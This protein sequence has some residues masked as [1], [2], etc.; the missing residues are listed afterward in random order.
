MIETARRVKIGFSDPTL[1][2]FS[3]F[4]LNTD[5]FCIPK[6]KKKKKGVKNQTELVLKKIWM[7]QTT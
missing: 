4:Y 7:S 6:G 2:Y 1:Y 5:N 3:A